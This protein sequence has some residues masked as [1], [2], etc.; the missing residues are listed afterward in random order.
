MGTERKRDAK[1]PAKLW[2]MA[3]DAEILAERKR[4]EYEQALLEKIK[5]EK[6]RGSKQRK[7]LTYEEWI[8]QKDTQKR[9]ESTGSLIAIGER[10]GSNISLSSRRDSN[11]SIDSRRGS[12]LS[13]ISLDDIKPA[14]KYRLTHEEWT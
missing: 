4:Q 5:S 11:C 7:Q 12:T 3:K 13:T 8:K 1:D 2:L 6:R 10:R 9:R 14:L